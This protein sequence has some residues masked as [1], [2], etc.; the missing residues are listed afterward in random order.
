[1]GN[2]DLELET[3]DMKLWHAD[4]RIGKMTM[5]VPPKVADWKNPVGIFE[6][7]IDGTKVSYLLGGKKDKPGSGDLGVFYSFASEN[8]HVLTTLT[9]DYLSRPSGVDDGWDKAAGILKNNFG[10]S[11]EYVPF[12]DPNKVA[13]IEESDPINW[14]EFPDISGAELSRI[15]AIASLNEVADNVG[16]GVARLDKYS[17]MALAPV[18][19]NSDGTSF[20][21]LEKA[22]ELMLKS[23]LQTRNMWRWGIL[24]AAIRDEDREWKNY[25]MNA[26]ICASVLVIY[27]DENDADARI[28]AAFSWAR[29]L[30]DV[31][32]KFDTGS[33]H[34]KPFVD[35][36]V[37]AVFDRHVAVKDQNGLTDPKV[38][39][40]KT[41][42]NGV[43]M[44]WGDPFLNDKH[45]LERAWPRA[46]S[47]NVSFE[48]NSRRMQTTSLTDGLY[49]FSRDPLHRR[50]IDASLDWRLSG[51]RNSYQPGFVLDLLSRQKGFPSDDYFFLQVTQAIAHM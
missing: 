45:W 11:N 34:R 9:E 19:L 3:H 25:W 33:E 44:T 28:K 22:S 24:D 2:A 32:L 43:Y 6:Q 35:A 31:Q 5:A 38:Y 49:N 27:Y 16:S 39:G 10:V 12:M 8:W 48:T 17:D 29:S 26:A 20:P 51:Y 23:V 37:N 4:G 41:S 50:G 21:I 14:G 40:D 47:G 46:D 30:A 7:D 15:L 36:D 13:G 42:A 1:M 18:E